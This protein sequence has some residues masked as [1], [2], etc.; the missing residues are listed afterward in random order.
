VSAVHAPHRA[1]RL[2]RLAR[3][4]SDD[5]EMVAGVLV[6]MLVAAAVAGWGLGTKPFWNDEAASAQFATR[7]FPQLLE[8]VATREH[9]MA[10]YQL[11][12]WPWSRVAGT[13]EVALRLPSLIFALA[14]IP[15]CV[16]VARRVLTLPW[17]LMSGLFLALSGYFVN[18]AQ[19]ARGYTMLLFFAVL[20]LWALLRAVELPTRRRWL[21][22]AGAA[23]LGIWSQPVMAFL[24][25]GH[26]AAILLHP[27][28]KAWWRHAVLAITL[29][30]LAVLPIALL[31]VFLGGG[32]WTWIG[33]A[34]IDHIVRQMRV[35]AGHGD[36]PALTLWAVAWVAGGAAALAGW[37][38]E[39]ERMWPRLVIL[40]SAL[41][42]ILGPL[43]VSV[44]RP[45]F[46][47]RY[48]IAAL[49]ALV[50]LGGLFLSSIRE[51]AI[52][53][54]LVAALLVVSVDGVLRWHFD[55]S[56]ADWR[57]ATAAVVERQRQGDGIAF[58]AGSSVFTAPPRV[59]R[60]YLTQLPSRGEPNVVRLAGP[61]TDP[62]HVRIGQ[63]VSDHERLW[64]VGSGW[65]RP[66][67]REAI[68]ELESV[69]VLSDQV[70]LEGLEVRL[71][72]R[73]SS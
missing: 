29:V 33:D 35:V 48:L 59:Y 63:A 34:S 20:A 42:P 52:A 70:H 56:R 50:I 68:S 65:N 51:R 36:L 62:L 28:A 60:Y 64:V 39:R 49:P 45:M 53:V 14:A 69:F 3:G 31:T 61:A 25:A 57:G 4:V 37:Y 55:V 71:Y 8:I 17:A 15:V 11:F 38:S 54:V 2:E 27:S 16:L 1:S 7:S 43:G 9:I 32:R 30:G 73:P 21:A 67:V 41:F 26:A 24:V 40:T 12:L 19:E 18:Y 72:I 22:Y 46:I 47:A 13:S 44:V 58:A 23:V 6:L 66:L 5:R 10:L